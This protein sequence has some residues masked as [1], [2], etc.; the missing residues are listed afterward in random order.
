[1]PGPARAMENTIAVSEAPPKEVTNGNDMPD[2]EGSQA[3]TPT[4]VENMSKRKKGMFPNSLGTLEP[5]QENII[6][7]LGKIQGVLSQDKIR[8]EQKMEAQQWT[9]WIIAQIQAQSEN[10][11]SNLEKQAEYPLTDNNTRLTNIEKALVEI[12]NAIEEPHKTYAQAVRGTQVA[13]CAQI[14]SEVAKRERLEQARQ[15]RA[16]TAV[17]LT[18]RDASESEQTVLKNRSESEYTAIFQGAIKESNAKDITIRKL[19]KLPG[20]L[21]KIHCHNEDDA[22][23]L[24][25]VEWEKTI[26]EVTLAS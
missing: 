7:M 2:E 19:Q 8:S 14:Q 24:R 17:T 4:E 25:E 5:T 9:S 10:T 18:F 11:S 21:L 1:M 6:K 16:K 15:E 20:K 23:Q 3:T 13:T 12:K 26:T 22:K